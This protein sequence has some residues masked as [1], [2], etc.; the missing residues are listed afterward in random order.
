MKE[1]IM[2]QLLQKLIESKYAKRNRMRKHHPPK[3]KGY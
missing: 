1:K 3:K 2:S